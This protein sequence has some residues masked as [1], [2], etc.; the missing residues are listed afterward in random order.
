M[1]S[2]ISC[3]LILVIA[4][5]LS[6]C[7]GNDVQGCGGYVKSDVEIDFSQVGIKLFTT[8]GSLKYETDCAPNDGYYFIPIDGHGNFIIK[9]APPPGWSVEPSEVPVSID[10]VSDLCSLEEDINFYFKGF[11][12]LGKVSS[13]AVSDT[14]KGPLGVAVELL[15]GSKIVQSTITDA[16]GAFVFTPLAAGEYSV[17]VSHPSW[18][19]ISDKVSVR[20]SDRNGEVPHGALVVRG[21]RVQGSVEGAAV[22]DVTVVLHTSD[23]ALLGH[24]KKFPP[25]CKVGS[26]S[27]Y[28][29][30]PSVGSVLCHVTT[31]ATG[32]YSFE[33]IVPSSY[34]LAAHRHT[35][36]TRYVISPETEAIQVSHGDLAVQKNFKVE[37]FS[38]SGVVRM[39]AEG[40]EGAQV[41]LGSHTTTTTA[42]GSYSFPNV[43][44]GRYKVTV[45]AENVEFDSTSVTV[46]PSE[47][48]V[49]PLTPSRFNV[50]FKIVLD[51]AS[52]SSAN[53]LGKW[54]ISVSGEGDAGTKEVSTDA[55]G[56]RGC[57]LLASSRYR[58]AVQLSQLQQRSGIRFGPVEH[59]FSVEQSVVPELV[60][61]QFLGEVTASVQCREACPTL[62]VRL[63]AADGTQRSAPTVHGKD[64]KKASVVFKEVVPG[65]YDVTVEKDDWCFKDQTLTAQLNSE[66]IAVT[67]SQS[68]YLLTVTSSHSADLAYS[69]S[70]SGKPTHGSFKVQKGTT[71]KCLSDPGSYSLTPESCHQF[72]SPS[73]SWT[74]SNP[75]LVSLVATRHSTS[76][77][78]ESSEP[79]SFTL[80]ATH[81]DGSSSILKPKSSSDNKYLFEDML[82]EGGRITLVPKSSDDLFQFQP[83]SHT[84]SVG[85]E[86]LSSAFSFKAEKALFISGSVKPP[87]AGVEVVVTG[88]DEKHEFITDRNGMYKAG[89][90]DNS[91]SYTITASLTGYTLTPLDD[92]GNFEAFKL[93]EVVVLIV[94]EQKKPLSGVVVSM[95]GGKSYRQNSLTA[96]DGLISFHSLLPGEYFVRTAMKEYNFEPPSKM[97]TVEQG[98]TINIKIK[99]IRVAYS[100][101]GMTTSLTGV[102]EQDVA[103]EARGV[104]DRCQQYQEEAVT[105]DSGVFRI[106]GLLPQCEY[107]IGLKTEASHNKHIERMLPAT[108]RVRVNKEDITGLKLVVLRHFTQMDVVG[109][110][111]SPKEHL[112][113]LSIKVYRDD[114]PD[115][116]VHTI[117]VGDHPFFMLPPMT[118]DWKTYTVSLDSSLST[119]QYSYRTPEVTFVADSSFKHIK[120][121]FRP[122]MKNIDAEMSHNTMAGLF[123]AVLIIAMMANYEKIAPAIDWI[124]EIIGEKMTQ[125]GNVPSDK[126][127]ARRL[128]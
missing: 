49:A 90:L 92:K 55:T 20:I 11:A 41:T 68:G 121:H 8:Q 51:D 95:S 109:T 19:F 26:P 60:F 106:R 94:D 35:P 87:V 2:R 114:V 75:S 85:S 79:G 98:A 27:G 77:V 39:G 125:M 15:K 44:P 103:V 21:Y 99:G 25:G 42:D 67:F 61:S 124:L 62:S 73:F 18:T 96:D 36:V 108:T 32:K 63:T 52:A 53:D 23:T 13:A 14:A 91:V 47:P 28:K 33:D 70:G 123:F 102:H 5:Y 105:D 10:G 37:G 126:T 76:G 80:L 54:I 112:S 34:T 30:S 116:P 113:S 9:V 46:S 118:A 22:Q 74:T 104:G 57:L 48:T 66:N 83:K 97:I 65:T 71:K 59:V 7:K 120:L 45:T 107:D 50:C 38:V 89:P 43:K 16:D 101:F 88:G 40:L 117:K 4:H 127:N 86:C 82:K 81:A 72:T 100:A 69:R 93:A 3:Y 78:L 84:F 1:T 122:T 29:P 111:E 17:S 6:W 12:V 24:Y 58:A 115:S 56:H 31:D 128:S 64:A 119:M 110:I